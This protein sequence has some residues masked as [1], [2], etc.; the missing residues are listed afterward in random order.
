MS[1]KIPSDTNSV[2]IPRKESL[3]KMG[4]RRNYDT[5]HFTKKQ[6]LLEGNVYCEA[7]LGVGYAYNKFCEDCQGMGQKLITPQNVLVQ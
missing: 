4:S 6:E 5:P 7:C 1:V 2:P 3:T